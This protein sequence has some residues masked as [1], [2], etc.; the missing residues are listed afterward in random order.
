MEFN[1]FPYAAHL[2]SVLLPLSHTRRVIWAQD[3]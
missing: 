1:G 2:K 3:V